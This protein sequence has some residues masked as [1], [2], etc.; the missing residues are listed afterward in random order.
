M[1]RVAH[2]EYHDTLNNDNNH[3]YDFKSAIDGIIGALT[4]NVGDKLV[5]VNGEKYIE[6]F[7]KDEREL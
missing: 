3:G 5:A 6:N 1:F 2:I 7:R 4:N